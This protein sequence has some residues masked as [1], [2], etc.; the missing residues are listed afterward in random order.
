MTLPLVLKVN[1]PNKAITSIKLLKETERWRNTIKVFVLKYF[2]RFY[3]MFT[4]V[5]IISLQSA[6]SI[7][8]HVIMH[9]ISVMLCI[10][11]HV[12]K[13]KN[14]KKKHGG[15][16]MIRILRLIKETFRNCTVLRILYCRI[17]TL[18]IL[19]ICIK[20]ILTPC[21]S[22]LSVF[23]WKKVIANYYR[24]INHL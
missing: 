13:R 2:W 5:H 16:T 21:L 6:S 9:S 1:N 19:Q 7:K 18:Y 10:L 14:I 22:F 20:T 8:E 24:K 17:N 4:Y 15:K 11:F 3:F 23:C 12:T